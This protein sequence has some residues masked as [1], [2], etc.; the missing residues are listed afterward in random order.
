MRRAVWFV[1]LYVAGVLTVGLIA[2]LI[3]LALA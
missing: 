2:W 3:R 1:G